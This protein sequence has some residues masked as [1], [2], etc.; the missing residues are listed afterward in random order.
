MAG[1]RWMPGGQ[2]WTADLPRAVPTVSDGLADFLPAGQ[3]TEP[4]QQPL[5]EPWHP[6]FPQAADAVRHAPP[7]TR[8]AHVLSM[9]LA[10]TATT[11]LATMMEEWIG[12]L[13]HPIRMNLARPAAAPPGTIHRFEVLGFDTGRF[14][15]GRPRRCRA[16]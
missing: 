14:H 7:D 15:S 16:R 2:D 3:D 12:D 13:P 6:S 10:A 8:T 4:W 9:S 1:F 5:F 11:E